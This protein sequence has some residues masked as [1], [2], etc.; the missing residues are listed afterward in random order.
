VGYHKLLRKVVTL[1]RKRKLIQ[2]GSKVLVAFSGGVDS[3]ALTLSF[4]D[5]WDFF[6]M[7]RLALAHINHGLREREAQRDEDFCIDFASR[8]GLEIFVKRI[9]VRELAV[10]RNL[11]E[12]ARE[13]RYK[14]LREI[15]ERESLDL[16][17]TAHH[18]K[19]LVETM[20]LWLV[21]GAGREGLLGFDEK[22]GDIVRPLYLVKREEIE[23]Y[24]KSKGESWVEDSTN[25][26]LR[27]ARN[28]IRH[29]VL[30]VLKSINSNLEESFLRLREV[31][32]EEENL[33]KE[34]T[35]RAIENVVRDGTIDREAFLNLPYALQRRVIYKLFGLRSL[36]EVD[37]MIN[38]LKRR[39]Y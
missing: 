34:L 5:L 23:D 25:Y 38:T 1:Q 9:K 37:R 8:K 27:F 4:L 33:L 39:A 31:L 32:K 22:E 30:P 6:K 29:R 21:R 12:A 36:K 20:L 35:E 17:A 28:R 2:E 7:G 10:G 24:V 13:E 19:D 11:E 15:K 18:L 3:V 16:I 26:D 14:A